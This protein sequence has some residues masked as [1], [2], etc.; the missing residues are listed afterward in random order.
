MNIADRCQF[1][2]RKM[3][4]IRRF[5]ETVER[6]F[7]EGRIMG[8]AHTCIGQEAVAVG[9][10]EALLPQDAIT[11]THRG[12]GHLIARGGDVGRMFAEL[13]GQPSGYSGGRGGSQ[14]MMAP[15]IGFY[16]S[17]GIVG[18]GI[19]FAAGL[20]LRAQQ[21]ASDRVVL[22][23]FGE[24]AANQGVFH[25]TLNLAALWRLP[26]VF[27]C[28]NNGYA[29]S[30]PAVK[31][32]ANPCVADRAA[33][34]R[35]RGDRVDGNDPVA[36][37]EKTSAAVAWARAGKGPVLLEALTYRLSGHS[38]GDPRV[39]RS[40][41]EESAARADDP[42]TRFRALILRERWLSESLLGAADA[43]V[44]AEIGQ[45]LPAEMMRV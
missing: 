35:M 44:E 43:E 22:C 11:S 39:Y 29:M 19:P 21:T 45:A 14:M 34:Y 23:F 27:L 20:A 37:W 36:V 18:A 13:M 6:L 31:G 40:R 41:E 25:E 33:A 8:T 30:T 1:F 17:N 16:G 12:H 2:Y 42:L 26:V 9:A 24:G 5:E 15:E 38:R 28:E 3:R 4:L 7:L 32:L 10:A